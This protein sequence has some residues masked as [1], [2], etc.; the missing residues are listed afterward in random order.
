MQHKR[1]LRSHTRVKWPKA[2]AL[3][4]LSWALLT[5]AMAHDTRR[6]PRHH[7]KHHAMQRQ[8]YAQHGN[9]FYDRHY[10]RSHGHASRHREFVVPV[11]LTRTA[12]ATYRNY[13]HGSIYYRPHR[14]YHAVYHFPV[15]TNAGWVSEPR[16][17]CN[18]DLYHGRERHHDHHVR[19]SIRF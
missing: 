7:G 11:R 4:A 16:Y 3:A 6:A 1:T 8:H 18:G 19:F 2:L 13:H 9:H 10:Y 14:H 5:P 17:Y 12:L 15:Y